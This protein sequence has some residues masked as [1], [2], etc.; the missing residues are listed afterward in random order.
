MA[1][2]FRPLPALEPRTEAFW[3][4][5]HA[6]RLEFTHCKPCDW[7]IHP[8]R[9]ICPKCRGRDLDIKAVSGRG[10][11]HSY[12]TNHHAWYPGMPVPY[13]VALVELVEQK[14]LR[15]MTN[16]INCPVE[17]VRIGMAVK[18]VFET[19]SE[20]V[21]LPLFEP[22]D[23]A[24]SEPVK[25]S[26]PAAVFSGPRWPAPT[27]VIER[28]AVISGVGQS[29][30]G[31]RLFRDDLDLTCEAAREAL[32]HAGLTVDDIDGVAAYP[33]PIQG[34]PGFAGP[35]I[36]EVQD[37]LGIDVRWHLSGLEGPA[38]IMPIIHAALAVS[39]GLCRHALVYRTVTEASAAADTGRRGIGAGSREIGGFGAFFIPFGAMSAGNWL[40]MYARR[41][42]HEFGTKREHLGMIAMNGRRNAGLNPKAVYREPMTMEDYLA[43]RLVSE[44]FGLFDCDAPVDGSTVVIISSAEAARDLR[45]P[46]VRFNAVGT[47]M[48]KRPLWDQWEDITTMAARDAAAHMWSRTDLKP[49]DV[50]TAQLYDGFSFLALAW[51]EALG[52]CG[53]GEGGPFVEGDRISL[54]G[55]L[56]INTWGG[57]LSGGRLHGFGFV[58]EAVRQ[59][60]GECGERQVKDCQVAAV[61]VGGG[62]VAGSLLLAR[63]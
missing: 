36:Y 37:A 50:D 48:N 5:C 61:G 7:Y 11:V 39:A 59:L 20:E 16:V 6:G 31:R 51:I 56:P 27:E 55:A 1:S 9:P 43:A 53:R 25:A 62:P 26:L 24:S 60:R 2:F 23:A 38:Q 42:M 32:D 40:A 44:P 54:S 17:S 8:S 12:T 35:S 19:V 4:A 22:D 52:F 28:R 46:A 63:D 41:H 45:G 10:R 15:L 13:N 30:I 21:A 29:A 47:A 49:S 14:N 18:V 3:K 34:G 58:A 57:Q 33:G